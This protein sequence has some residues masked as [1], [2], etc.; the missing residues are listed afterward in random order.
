M[1]MTPADEALVRRMEHERDMQA[2]AVRLREALIE[3][4]VTDMPDGLNRLADGE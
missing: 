1:G 4:G 3:A 2:V